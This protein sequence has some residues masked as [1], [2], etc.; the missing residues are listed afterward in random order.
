MKPIDVFRTW[1]VVVAL[2]AL[3]SAGA[4]GVQTVPATDPAATLAEL[5]VDPGRNR[6]LFWGVGG[7]ALA[8]D[9]EARYT[10]LEMKR[11]IRR[12]PGGLVARTPY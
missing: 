7:R 5:W 4:A 2:A 1:A 11:L 3:A 9:P 10:V 6:D 8:P 12:L